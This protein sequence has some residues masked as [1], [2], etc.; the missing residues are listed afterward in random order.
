M[1]KETFRRLKSKTPKYFNK[2]R[3]FCIAMTGAS[4][5]VI[6]LKENLPLYVT[7]Q[8]PTIVTFGVVGTFFSSL[9][10][11]KKEDQTTN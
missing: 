3:N 4:G 8:V 11:E 10:E 1:I 7:K 6:L 2:L 5:A 9:P